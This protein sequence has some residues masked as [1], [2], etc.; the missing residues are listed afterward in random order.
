MFSTCLNEVGRNSFVWYRDATTQLMRGE[1][2]G[3]VSGLTIARIFFLWTR[4]TSLDYQNVIL[5]VENSNSNP[6]TFNFFGVHNT[7]L[8]TWSQFT[9]RLN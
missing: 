6:I 7:A 3:Y 9:R 5:L 2:S 8:S 1:E 4:I